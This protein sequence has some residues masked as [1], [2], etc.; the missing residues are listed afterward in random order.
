LVARRLRTAR[1]W[2][3]EK[4][5]KMPIRRITPRTNREQDF[6]LDV[7][8]VQ[9]A[10]EVYDGSLALAI[11]HLLNH[12]KTLISVAYLPGSADLEQ[13]LKRHPEIR[14]IDDRQPFSVPEIHGR[15]VDRVLLQECQRLLDGVLEIARLAA[16]PETAGQA[17][18][19]LD[20]LQKA[21]PFLDYRYDNDPFPSDRDHEEFNSPPSP[22]NE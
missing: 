7:F 3:Q 5:R 4:E 2:D 8:H 22:D 15:T 19:E 16:W 1:Y 18:K 13:A 14:A 10:I 21:V 17:Q 11:D 6:S 12:I 9:E 20:E